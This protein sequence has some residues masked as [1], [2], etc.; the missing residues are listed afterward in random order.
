MPAELVSLIFGHEREGHLRALAG[1]YDVEGW[2]LARA[3]FLRE[4][5]AIEAP[6]VVIPPVPDVS[7]G[8]E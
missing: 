7:S 2:C 8:S 3:G 4:R 6:H 5:L 1:Q